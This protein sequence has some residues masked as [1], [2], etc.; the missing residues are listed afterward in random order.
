M[1]TVNKTE[2]KIKIFNYT[3]KDLIRYATKLKGSNLVKVI[4]LIY[5]IPRGG[6]VPSVVLSHYFNIPVIFSQSVSPITNNSH[7]LI[8]D[9]VLETGTTLEKCVNEVSIFTKNIYTLCLIN[10]NSKG[11]PSLCFDKQ[12]NESCWVVFPW[13]DASNAYIDKENREHRMFK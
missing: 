3:W 2:R 9:D 4:D 13:E 12:V 5:G 11:Y 8:V 7:I 6:V 10:K 1:G